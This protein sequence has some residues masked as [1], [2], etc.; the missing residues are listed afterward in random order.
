MGCAFSEDEQQALSA[1]K[2]DNI[3]PTALQ[4][5]LNASMTNGWLEAAEKIVEE[6]KHEKVS[7]AFDR[8]LV[9][10]TGRGHIEAMRAA[11]T[12]GAIDFAFAMFKAAKENQ[13]RA[14]QEVRSWGGR[15]T[16]DLN[17]ALILAAGEGHIEAMRL[18]ASWGAHDFNLA[19]VYAA[20][21]G[22]IKAMRKLKYW[23]AYNF[24]QALRA[25]ENTEAQSLLKAWRG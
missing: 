16:P 9:L 25:T 11:R 21:G 20:M 2:G 12:W 10:A 1:V 17:Q 19:L 18:L 7:L 5:A 6:A 22:H 3:P 24:D 15:S 8:A 14:M 23:G 13:L 4:R